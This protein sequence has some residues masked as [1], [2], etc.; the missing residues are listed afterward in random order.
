MPGNFDTGEAPCKG[1]LVDMG[2]VQDSCLKNVAVVVKDL[3]PVGIMVPTGVRMCHRHS[4]LI[5][6]TVVS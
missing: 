1:L 6:A 2:V 4:E 5:T 3:P